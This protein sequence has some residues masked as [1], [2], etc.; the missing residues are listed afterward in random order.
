VVKFYKFEKIKELELAKFLKLI[1]LR[2]LEVA[3]SLK[4]EKPTTQK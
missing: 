4:F 3:S 1:F 2:E